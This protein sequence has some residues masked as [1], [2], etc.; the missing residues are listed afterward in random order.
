MRAA[1]LDRW[2]AAQARAGATVI[3]VCGGYQ[4]MGEAIEDPF[5]LESPVR[6]AA[7]LGLLPVRT[8]SEA[9]EDHARGRGSD[10]VG[11]PVRSLR[12]S[13]G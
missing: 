11:P 3:G 5:G 9:R 12:N 6:E 2:I 10:A 13:H 1:G 7:G 4:M 8:V